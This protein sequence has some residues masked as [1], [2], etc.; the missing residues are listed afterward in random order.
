MGCGEESCIKGE[1]VS[2]KLLKLGLGSA[3][4]IIME[5]VVLPGCCACWSCC[6]CSCCVNWSCCWWKL[7]GML[8][9][10]SW[11]LMVRMIFFEVMLVPL[12]V[13]C[14]LACG[15]EAAVRW[16]R[17]QRSKEKRKGGRGGGG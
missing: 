2:I 5:L 13:A 3:G 12:M 17:L 8:M 1:S 10:S 7:S 11:P 16:A 9:L 15:L 6:C 14:G 4:E